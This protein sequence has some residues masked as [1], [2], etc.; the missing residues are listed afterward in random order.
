VAYFLINVSAPALAPWVVGKIADRA[1]LLAGMQVAVAAQ[2]VGG[3][4][5]LLVIYF[6]RRDGLH[7]PVLEPY[8]TLPA[9]AAAES[10][11]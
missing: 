10:A 8:R 1:G 4:L 7:H 5:Y 9:G 3:L 11:G 2:L 6:I